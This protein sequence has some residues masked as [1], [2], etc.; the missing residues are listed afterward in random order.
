[1]H[2]TVIFH[3][4]REVVNILTIVNNKKLLIVISTDSFRNRSHSKYR[5][6]SKEYHFTGNKI[7]RNI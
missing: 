3:P 4:A 5:W 1:M 6:Y 7:E 2:H